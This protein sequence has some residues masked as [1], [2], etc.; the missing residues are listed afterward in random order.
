MGG[1]QQRNV[2]GR[3]FIRK[4]L[5]EVVVQHLDAGSVVLKQQFGKSSRALADRWIDAVQVGAGRRGWVALDG[6]CCRFGL[7]LLTVR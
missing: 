3:D 5:L 1:P 6:C 7:L 4:V 2:Y